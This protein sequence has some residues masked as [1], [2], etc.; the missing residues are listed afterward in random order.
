[1]DTR[2]YTFIAGDTG[3]WNI[4]SIQ[5]VSGQSLKAAPRLDIQN[6]HLP[7]P[8]A[9]AG[10]ML[11]GVTSHPRYVTRTEQTALVAA[12][13]GLGRSEATCAAFIPIT[14]TAAWWALTQDERRGIFEDRSAH[15]ATGLRYLPA[16][17]RRLHHSRDLGE[18]FD[19]L[20]WFEY[21]PEDA[22]AFDDLVAALR[23]TE[24]WN[25]VEREVDI[26]LVRSGGIPS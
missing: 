10:W 20:T 22:T 14:K 12:Q 23:T 7:H 6:A 13:A 4:V 19:F 15:I 16:I 3:P 26:R 8:P 18:P 17:A 5:A 9:G 11:R 2:F 21:A 25:Y 24:E 1:M